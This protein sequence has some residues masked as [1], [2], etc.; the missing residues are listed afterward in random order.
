M[1]H[2]IRNNCSRASGGLSIF[3]KNTIPA[4]VLYVNIPDHLEVMYVSIRPKKL[5]RTVSNIVLC[6]LYY[7]GSTSKYAPPQDDLIF[8]VIE[9]IQN[10]HIK[11]SNPLI[12]LVGDF[13][14]LNIEDICESCSLKQVVKV[15]TRK[16]AI[17][18]LILTNVDSIFYND[19][20]TL[21]S[22][23]NSDHLC[24]VYMPKNY[25]KLENTK[26]KIMIRKFKESEKPEFGSWITTFDWSLLFKIKC[27]NE[28]VSY[29]STITWL[30]IEKYFLVQKITISSSDKE[31]MTVKI[32]DLINQR[33]KAHKAGNLELKN[34]LA[35]KVRF[36]IRKAKVN[37]NKEKAH[38]FHMS[39]PQE[40]Y[41]HI[42]KIMG[43][44]MKN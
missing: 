28:K 25:I 22:I 33:Q 23:G 16:D 4:N 36:E 18:D 17:L 6:A 39:N 5:P 12:I 40:W 35:K 14:D 3:V 20:I 29:F 2:S 21:P 10:F 24:V 9:S 42:N 13:N 34:N 26:K 30:M 43:N 37:Y 1:F 19:P 15:P 8:Y 7:P 44:K 27:V 11:Y 31:W 32:K 38:L 41:R